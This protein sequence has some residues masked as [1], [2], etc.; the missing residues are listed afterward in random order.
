MKIAV[1]S[2]ATKNREWLY[3]ITN[4]VKQAYCFKH[5]YDF[6]F[7][8][9][10]LLPDRHPSWGKL[11]VVRQ[12]LPRYDWVMWI[13]DDAMFANF[14]VDLETIIQFAQKMRPRKQVAAIF[15]NDMEG[16]NAGVFLVRN[17]VESMR[18]FDLWCDQATYKKFANASNWEQ[19]VFN[20]LYNDVQSVRDGTFLVDM[21]TMNSFSSWMRPDVKPG[22]HEYVVGDFVLHM[23][24]LMRPKRD[25]TRTRQHMVEIVSEIAGREM[26]Q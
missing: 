11:M 10:N 13:D 15:A 12:V 18:I 17:C 25:S 21:R 19:A 23:C 14:E 3:S 8:T 4:P 9:E 6:L 2:Y 5:G 16:I 24:G 20:A 1:V 22:F 7:S 26:R